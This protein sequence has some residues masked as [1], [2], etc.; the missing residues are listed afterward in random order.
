MNKRPRPPSEQRAERANRILAEMVL[1]SPPRH[2]HPSARRAQG[3]ST[4]P[5]RVK[6]EEEAEVAE[7][8]E[9]DSAAKPVA[10]SLLDFSYILSL[11][12]GGCCANVYTYEYMLRLDPHLGT[13]LTFSQMVFVTLHSLPSFIVWRRLNWLPIPVSIPTL[14]M[15]PR[16]VPLSQWALQVFVLTTGSLLNNWAFGFS[17]PLTVQIIFRSAGLA[18]SMLF[19][20]LFLAK[21]Y[22]SSQIGAVLL[23]TLGVTLATTSRPSSTKDTT[24]SNIDVSQ[25]TIGVLMLTTSLLLTGV[26]GIL[27]ERTYTRYGP[28]WK[29]GVFYTHALSL[30]IFVIFI[31]SVK[32]GFKSLSQASAS[33]PSDSISDFW[34]NDDDEIVTHPLSRLVALAQASFM[35]LLDIPPSATFNAR[36]YATLLVN[37]ITQ[38]ACVSGV[39]QM[40]SR[41]SSV[42]TN[43]VLTARKAISLCFSVWWFGNGWNAQLGTGAGMVFL[44]SILYTMVTSRTAAPLQA[45]GVKAHS[46]QETGRL[47][48]DGEL[49][50]RKKE[51]KRLSREAVVK[52]EAPPP[53][54]LLA[55][56][57]DKG[58]ARM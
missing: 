21:R 37:L 5:Q 10:M 52:L 17:V 34:D 20:R 51:G 1:S 28:C 29:E 56:R 14:I 50:S 40:T 39:N 24:A 41:I 16:Q 58:K 6:V 12:F 44:G 32:R 49:T 2:R 15:K 35:D 9:P 54:P 7:H 13:A 25:Y 46:M 19:G 3:T 31:P 45:Q 27:Q 48:E 55:N 30:P 22:S 11:V 18:V 33:F 4:D 38:L 43:V 53:E 23:V 8:E 42:S 36:P 26:L 47:M 57:K